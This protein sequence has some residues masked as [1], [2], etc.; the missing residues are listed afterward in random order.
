MKS[1]TAELWSFEPL[2]AAHTRHEH[3]LA[4]NIGIW[5][6]RVK[7]LEALQEA[8]GGQLTE[9]I[10]AQASLADARAALSEVHE[11]DAKLRADRIQTEN[12]VDSAQ[13]QFTLAI[14]NAASLLEMEPKQLLETSTLNPNSLPIWRRIQTLEIRAR[15]AGVVESID[16]TN[17]AWVERGTKVMTIVQPD[18]L[19]STP[20]ACRAILE[21]WRTVFPSGSC[22]LLQRPP[23]PPYPYTTP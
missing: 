3:N 17:G 7:K 10:A 2:M 4:Q 19:A 11:E 23:D 22:L 21:S 16:V 1:A 8:G 6:D 18:R 20:S 9:L 13:S 12:K 5:S 14:D 15:Q